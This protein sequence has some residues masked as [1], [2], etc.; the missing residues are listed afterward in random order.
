MKY[1]NKA[2]SSDQTKVILLIGVW[3]KN[4]DLMLQI[5]NNKTRGR[6]VRELF[7]RYRQHGPR[8]KLYY[9]TIMHRKDCIY[10]IFIPYLQDLGLLKYCYLP[11]QRD[12]TTSLSIRKETCLPLVRLLRFSVNKY[13][14]RP[15]PIVLVKC[16]K[17]AH[18]NAKKLLKNCQKSKKLLPKFQKLLPK[19]LAIFI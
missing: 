15:I 13:S 12:V 19:F 5:M 9:Y 1:A 8:R 18:W 17:V 3:R 10:V 2:L 6:E 11:W 7:G 4:H 14:I 16:W